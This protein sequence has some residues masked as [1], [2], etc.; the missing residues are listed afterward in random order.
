MKE[1]RDNDA[2]VSAIKLHMVDLFRP[3]LDRDILDLEFYIG[4]DAPEIITHTPTS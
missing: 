3:W 1:L 4:P 2:Q